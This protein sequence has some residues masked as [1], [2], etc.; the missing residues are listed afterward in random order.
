MESTKQVIYNGKKYIILH[1]YDSGYCEIKEE[2]NQYNVELVN[3]L[4]L[5][6]PVETISYK[7]SKL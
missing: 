4:D 1:M 5:Q 3:F 2:G 7:K 6:K